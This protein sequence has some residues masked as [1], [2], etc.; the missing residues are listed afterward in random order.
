M[1]SPLISAG[2]VVLS[3][4]VICTPP[5]VRQWVGNIVRSTEED[6]RDS[7]QPWARGRVELPKKDIA[8]EGGGGVGAA[9]ERKLCTDH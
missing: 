7:L 1:G 3:H 4:V 5:Q 6:S 2:S 9:V 8:H